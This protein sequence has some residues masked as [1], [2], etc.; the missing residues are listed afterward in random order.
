MHAFPGLTCNPC[1][2]SVHK[3]KP[4][5]NRSPQDTNMYVHLD[6]LKAEMM[7]CDPYTLIELDDARMGIRVED[8]PDRKLRYQARKR[9]ESSIQYPFPA[10]M[11]TYQR[12]G[13]LGDW[14][15]VF[16]MGMGHDQGHHEFINAIVDATKDAPRRL[17]CRQTNDA[18]DTIARATGRDRR[19]CRA[20]LM[21]VLEDGTYPT[22]CST[23][24]EN[25]F[26]K[27]VENLVLCMD[28]DSDREI[29]TDMRTFNIRGNTMKSKFGLFW[30]WCNRTL[31]FENGSG[32]HHRRHA[33]GD[34]T[35][36]NEISFAP[37]IMSIRELISKTVEALVKDG[38]VE[39]TDFAVPSECW[40]SLQLSPNN[41]FAATAERYTGRLPYVRKMI[42][43]SAR[44]DS[45][46]AARWN[47][48]MKKNWRSHTAGLYGLIEQYNSSA[49]I[50]TDGAE[51]QPCESA[52][53]AIVRAGCDDKTNI[54]VGDEIPLEAAARQSRRAIVQRNTDVVAGDHNF[55]AHKITPSVIHFMNQSTE[56]GDSLY[57]GGPEGT[58]RTYVSLHDAVMDPS[59][60]YKHAAHFNDWL[61]RVANE[62]SNFVLTPGETRHFTKGRAYLVLIECDGGPDHNLTHL[63]NQL[64]LFGLFLQG[65]M[66]KLCATRGCAG[67]SYLNTAE[68]PMSLLTLGQ[69]GLATQLD[70]TKPDFLNE[71]LRNASSMKLIRQNITEYDELLPIA[72]AALERRAARLASNIDATE[73]ITESDDSESLQSDDEDVM[74]LPKPGD[75]LRKFF[76]FFGWFSGHVLQILEGAKEGKCIRMKYEDGDTE[77]LTREAYHNGIAEA[78]IAP[79]DVG[80]KFVKRFQGNWYSGEVIRILNNGKRVCRFNDDDH[81]EYSLMQVRLL[82]S[83]FATSVRVCL[84]TCKLLL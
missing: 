71:L 77:D 64:A 26:A 84:L 57:S 33:V 73:V 36:T 20:I 60:G 81:R 24:H 53:Q 47:C 63:S 19:I 45:H 56:P 76:P 3:R 83:K 66:D 4:V 7:R 50:L 70:P 37:G 65:D 8:M 75:E 80:T 18:I 51:R 48:V 52:R 67:L 74:P 55:S 32:A 82:V 9:F 78:S 28:G 2:T 6:D 72:I 59:N 42:S 69:S 15:V 16:R 13:T 5:G 62:D 30:E 39:G 54:Q 17:S 43:R 27:D 46:P 23:I 35:T 31:D 25:E 1:F 34:A 41:Q 44:D 12:H 22:F 14:T 10:G 49:D 29:I 58:G 40:V 79:G 38:K 11:F 61:I 21:T 68:R